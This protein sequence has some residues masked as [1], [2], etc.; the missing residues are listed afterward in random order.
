MEAKLHDL[1]IQEFHGDGAIGVELG[2]L[3]LQL[4]LQLTH[5]ELVRLEQMSPAPPCALHP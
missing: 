5:R 4:H 1:L 3:G 2:V